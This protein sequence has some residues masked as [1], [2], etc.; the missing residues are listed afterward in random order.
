M[1]SF[2]E[3]VSVTFDDCAMSVTL[4]DGRTITVPLTWYPSLLH[5][6]AAQRADFW[7]SPGGVHWDALDEDI[8]V[9][10]MLGARWQAPDV[11]HAA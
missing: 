9:E 3:P 2:P 7:L 8:S 10:G 1:Y 6:T 11:R 4:D 5:A